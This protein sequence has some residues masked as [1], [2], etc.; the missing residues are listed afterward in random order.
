[1]CKCLIV[2]KCKISSGVIDFIYHK[3]NVEENSIYPVKVAV[4]E[5]N[6]IIMNLKN[7]PGLLVI[8]VIEFVVEVQFESR[9]DVSPKETE[10]SPRPLPCPCN[11][12]F[13]F[14][15]RILRSGNFDV[16]S[17]R[18]SHGCGLISEGTDIRSIETEFIDQAFNIVTELY[19]CKDAISQIIKESS[20]RDEKEPTA[21][22]T[23][24]SIDPADHNWIE[25]VNHYRGK[26]RMILEQFR[27]LEGKLG[28]ESISV[29]GRRDETSNPSVN[30]EPNLKEGDGAPGNKSSKTRG[31]GTSTPTT[32]YSLERLLQICV[33]RLLAEDWEKIRQSISVQVRGEVLSNIPNGI[34]VFN[35]LV[36]RNLV[37]NHNLSFL[38]NLFYEIQRVD[39]V[40]LMDC[41]EEGDYSLLSGRQVEL[42]QS[43]RY[44]VPFV[45]SGLTS[46]P[47]EEMQRLSVGRTRHATDRPP[48]A[49]DE[50]ADARG[51]T[52]KTD[53]D[54]SDIVPTP[55]NERFE[56]SCK[57]YDRYCD[58]KFS[59]CERF[60][61]CHRCH[62]ADSKCGR[63]NLR[64]R[65]IVK[66]KCKRCGKIQEVK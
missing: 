5:R 65:D 19:S 44:D 61:P 3:I 4:L 12:L 53:L 35:E 26:Y 40:H 32:T 11:D 34:G 15:E 16:Y 66:I 27:V 47:V 18:K 2:F 29:T 37:G 45:N 7:I 10:R 9:I 33:N 62:N 20:V 25:Q 14:L 22:A 28:V 43:E 41:I 51:R 6:V 54:A 49:V 56:F 21:T 36:N 31:D 8:Q 24:V 48:G 42:P 58:V 55:W 13:D 30:I 52:P 17:L 64:S 60:W 39:L 59:C 1:M 38:R 57:H 50:T 23:G 46:V 63:K